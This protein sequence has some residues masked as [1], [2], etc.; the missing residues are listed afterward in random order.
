[1][2][3]GRGHVVVVVDRY[4]SLSETFVHRDLLRMEEAGLSL[5]VV[6]CRPGSARDAWIETPLAARIVYP[7]SR[8]VATA[9]HLLHAVTCG[10]RAAL[11]LLPRRARSMVSACRAAVIAADFGEQLA[12][13]P[14]DWIHAH[15]MGRPAVVG[16]LL[17][18]S[19]GC[20]FS[21]SV[22]A[23]DV[24]IPAA[25]L[26]R[27]CERARFVAACSEHA[28]ASL[29]G[30]L[31]ASLMERI[32]QIAHD[33]EE[34]APGSN[35]RGTTLQL[36]SVCRLV[37][38]K[39]IDVILKALA[40]LP[41]LPVRYRVIGTG[42][43][44][45]AAQALVDEFGLSRRVE[46]LGALTPRQIAYELAASD[47]FVLGS[48]VAPDGDRDGIPN[49][50]LEAMMAGIPVVMGDAGAV[51]EVIEHRRTGW[52]VRPEDA[53]AFASAI[54]E[55]ARDAELRD[56]VAWNGRAEVQRRF[57]TRNTRHSLAVRL[58]AELHAQ[59]GCSGVRSNRALAYGA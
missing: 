7:R 8:V 38:K 13:R 21:V 9:P 5:T 50:M 45:P 30:Q 39:G 23:R 20:P 36:I 57:S 43:E 18:S 34:V 59:R 52:L 19:R 26:A 25:D 24:F 28:R 48:R 11:P 40:L 58:V 4:P 2:M 6:S 12:A 46:F 42:P 33:V 32:V 54:A 31:P 49:A 56:A 55:A 15:F 17:A 10:T 37:R 3:R 53:S 41:D 1:M 44:L 29:M 51:G 27:V 14:V 16:V 47:L 35:R 22:H